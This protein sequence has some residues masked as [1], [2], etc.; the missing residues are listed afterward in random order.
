MSLALIREH[1][2]LTQQFS[3]ATYKGKS[4]T[5]IL[6]KLD[7]N[8]RKFSK[9]LKSKSFLSIFRQH[10]R[11]TA[12]YIIAALKCPCV[13]SARMPCEYRRDKQ[14]WL[15]K[16]QENGRKMVVQ[17]H[18]LFPHKSKKKIAYYWTQHLT[19]T[20]RY[21]QKLK[22]SSRTQYVEAKKD[23]LKKGKNM[24]LYLTKQE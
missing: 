12:H 7:N 6:T 2:L 18:K 10:N 9:A 1:I 14:K 13:K 5:A 11:Y 3:E 20:A 15:R 17:L 19:C 24:I 23:C 8:A 4:T 16:L 22:C 21:V